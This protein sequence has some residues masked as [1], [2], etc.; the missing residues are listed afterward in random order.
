MELPDLIARVVEARPD[1]V[2][3]MPRT[4]TIE[5][6]G[7]PATAWTRGALVFA[8]S[9]A[10]LIVQGVVAEE[11]AKVGHITHISATRW[12]AEWHDKRGKARDVEATT[13]LDAAVAALCE[14][15]RTP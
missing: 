5:W 12:D 15:A 1:L 7:H 2:E 14:I 9:D 3:K 10:R 6:G 8:E 11:L 4:M 13:Y